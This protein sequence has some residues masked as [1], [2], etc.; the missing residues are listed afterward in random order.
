MEGE[1]SFVP[2]PNDS[3]EQKMAK[4]LRAYVPRYIPVEA[5]PPPTDAADWKR[6][7]MT[8]LRARLD[9]SLAIAPE[10]RAERNERLWPRVAAAQFCVRYP[11]PEHVT[12][13]YWLQTHPVM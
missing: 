6:Y 11:T 1:W 2:D 7:L 13:E 5:G 3:E 9:E 10:Y 12:L 4:W 8:A